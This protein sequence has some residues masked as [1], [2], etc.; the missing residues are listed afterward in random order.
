MWGGR[1]A[2]PPD[3]TTWALSI[4]HA[5][6]R[7]LPED[8]AGSIAHVNMLGATGIISDQEAEA[9]RQGLAA[10]ADEASDGSFEFTE[11]DEDVHSAVE[12]RL[13]ELVGSVAGKLHTGR[14]RNDQVALDLRLYLRRVGE[15]RITQLGELAAAL[16][17][18]AEAVGETVVSAYTHL[19]PSQAVPLGHYLLG[20]AWPLVRDIERFES[21]IKRMSVSPLG[22]GAGGG[23]SLPIDPGAVAVELGMTGVFDNSLDAVAARDFV[24]EY[25]FCC[26]QA[27]ANVSRLAEELV[28]WGTEEFGWATYSDSHTTGSSALP[29]K[30]NPDVA[31]LARGKAA[32]TSGVVGSLLALQKGLPL[33]Y[34]RDLQE[35]K[36]LVFAAD[37][38]LALSLPALAAMVGGAEFHPPPASPWVA[39]LDLAEAL[40]GRGVPFREAHEAVG[41]LVGKLQATERELSAI[42]ANELAAAHEQLVPADLEL[43]DPATSV[44]QRR[45]PGGGSFESVAAQLQA[46][47]LRLTG[48]K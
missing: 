11:D 32:A 1:F 26:A 39:A 4:S 28:L 40:V 22:A 38:A 9:L 37:D 24:A 23:T 17:N 7:L 46:L 47:K 16:A 48:S 29:H 44:T 5:D 31:E 45:S 14:S 3:E 30:K 18:Q 13:I 35:D 34:N 19:Q 8:I 36:E 15:Q 43:L 12:R 20:H 41:E 25:A 33:A 21:A 42:D 6:R 27:M 2:E 10:M